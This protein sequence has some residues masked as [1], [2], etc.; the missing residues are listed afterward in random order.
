MVPAPDFYWIYRQNRPAYVT[1]KGHRFTVHAYQ[2]SA[3][4]EMAS[5]PR[6]CPLQADIA[7]FAGYCTQ[8]WVHVRGRQETLTRA[9][10]NAVGQ[11][12]ARE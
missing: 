10:A 5:V 1:A 3:N 8:V 7:Q 6:V 2:T 9:H 4:A 12:R 11:I